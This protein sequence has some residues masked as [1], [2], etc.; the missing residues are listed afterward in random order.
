M[1]RQE[2]KNEFRGFRELQRSLRD[3]I[4]DAIRELF[5]EQDTTF[6]RSIKRKIELLTETLRLISRY[7]CMS[8]KELSFI[9]DFKIEG[10]KILLDNARVTEQTELIYDDLAIMEW[11]RYMSVS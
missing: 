7:P 9:I 8:I 1:Q 10:E 11:I 4:T 6:N 2:Q 5:P 3:E